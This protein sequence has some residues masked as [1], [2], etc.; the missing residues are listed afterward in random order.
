VRGVRCTGDV[1]EVSRESFA[2]C[3]VD[4]GLGG[5]GTIVSDWRGRRMRGVGE[6]V[7]CTGRKGRRTRREKEE[8]RGRDG[9]G[10]REAFNSQRVRA[11]SF[12]GDEKGGESYDLAEVDCT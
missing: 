6:D 11:H 1:D 5:E 3:L 2:R 7:P 4:G 10:E 8:R 12:D 9:D